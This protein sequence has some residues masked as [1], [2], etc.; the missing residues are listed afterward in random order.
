MNKISLTF[1]TIIVGVLLVM[2]FLQMEKPAFEIENQ[3]I[4]VPQNSIAASDM[5]HIINNIVN[6]ASEQ[7]NSDIVQKKRAMVQVKQLDD[8]S[9]FQIFVLAQS[10]KDVEELNEQVIY[11][12]L[13]DVS[14]YYDTKTAINIKLIDSS[15][16]DKNILNGI[17]PIVFW[18]LVGILVSILVVMIVEVVTPQNNRK[19]N[20]DFKNTMN[21][22]PERV[23]NLVNEKGTA[24][25]YDLQSAV[26]SDYEFNSFQNEKTEDVPDVKQQLNQEGEVNVTADAD[27]NLPVEEI[28]EENEKNI[29]KEIEKPVVEQIQSNSNNI[30]TSRSGAPS[31][32]PVAEFNAEN[33]SPDSVNVP[34]TENNLENG[35]PTEDELKARLNKLLKGEM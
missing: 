31:N 35:E 6:I 24:P 19:V 30:S 4:I 11:N 33:N 8:A 1:V 15:K 17:L 25:V 20:A 3:F 28:A 23:K 13:K 26:N 14:K 5:D 9:M 34:T 7:Q 10:E 21:V 22:D 32:L 12:V 2:V 27:E 18:A 16:N 29:I